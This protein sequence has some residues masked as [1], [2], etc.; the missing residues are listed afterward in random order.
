M[1]R[2]RN[3]AKR[4]CPQPQCLRED[5]DTS[6]GGKDASRVDGNSYTSAESHIFRHSASSLDMPPTPLGVET[7]IIKT[8]MRR[9]EGRLL[10]S[11]TIYYVSDATKLTLLLLPLSFISE[12]VKTNNMSVLVFHF[13]VKLL[14]IVSN[15]VVSLSPL[16]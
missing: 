13:S 7:L 10:W 14:D 1:S 2:A 3:C 15:L 5:L 16:Q 11:G 4:K 8:V 9:L 6:L 12:I